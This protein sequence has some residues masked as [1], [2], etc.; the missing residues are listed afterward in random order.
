MRRGDRADPSRFRR[1]HTMLRKARRRCCAAQHALLRCGEALRRAACVRAPRA[2]L[3]RHIGTQRRQIDCAPAVMTDAD[4]SAPRPRPSR[5]ELRS[6]GTCTARHW[7]GTARHARSS[8]ERAGAVGQ[9]PCWPAACHAARG[10]T[11]CRTRR[12]GRA[13]G[14]SGEVSLGGAQPVLEAAVDRV[15]VCA[16][17]YAVA[18]ASL[19]LRPENP[20]REYLRVP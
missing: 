7:P 2:V 16:V 1:R 4:A 11:L 6:G 3:A 17:R 8:S 14:A 13:S 15:P 19:A 9:R 12:T 5:P 18:E 10:I 20:P